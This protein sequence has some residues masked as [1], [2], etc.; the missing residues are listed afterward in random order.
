MRRLNMHSRRRQTR[1][2][3]IEQT[4]EHCSGK[5]LK[6][7]T[8]AGIPES[9]LVDRRGKPCPKCG[10]CDRFS[11][12]SDLAIRGAV[13]C[14]HC[15]NA[16]TVPRA[17]DGI[18]TLC[19]WLNCGLY[20]ALVWLNNWIKGD[21]IQP[22]HRFV[23]QLNARVSQTVERNRFELLADICRRNLCRNWLARA[24]DLLGL[25][26]EPLVKLGVGW[27]PAHQATTWPMLD[28]NG[29]VI[30]IRLRCPTTGRK[31][32]VKGSNAGLFYSRELLSQRMPN[33]LMVCEGPT[34]TAAL[35]SIGMTVVGVPSAGGS[36]ELLDA[37]CRRIT[38]QEITIVADNDGPGLTGA[39]RLA[40]CLVLVAP[41]RLISPC[42]GHKDSRA[43]VRAGADRPIIASAADSAVL[44]TL[45]LKGVKDE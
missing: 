1:L 7:L 20:D 6:V 28:A 8:D 29:S 15:H 13:L 34:D 17:G 10:G 43:W 22:I 23:P 18:A 12:M 45:Q 27:S 33:R 3:S 4:K 14:R 39:E 19:W 26:A 5:W 30:G 11:A 35:L 32:A 42:G 24:A 2:I 36:R 41:V 9:A 44:R 37:L 38:P 31:W 21:K 40:D 16:S 25:P